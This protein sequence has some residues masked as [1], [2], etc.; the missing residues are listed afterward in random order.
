VGG[1]SAADNLLLGSSVAAAGLGSLDDF[2]EL[3]ATFRVVHLQNSIRLGCP[4]RGVRRC[5]SFRR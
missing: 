2:V 1:G 3:H 5:Q 4:S